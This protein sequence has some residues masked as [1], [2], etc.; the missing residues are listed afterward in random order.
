MKQ[1]RN[2]M[3]ILW[4]MLALSLSLALAACDS[5][6]QSPQNSTSLE[7]SEL[8]LNLRSVPSGVQSVMVTVNVTDLDTSNFDDS[9]NILSNHKVVSA[10]ELEKSNEVTL[11]VRAGTIDVEVYA[12][13]YVVA[14]LSLSNPDPPVNSGLLYYGKTQVVVAVS[15]IK[16]A[17]VNLLAAQSVN[18]Q[19]LTL[20]QQEDFYA[21]QFA[22]DIELPTNTPATIR[23]NNTNPDHLTL[24]ENNEEQAVSLTGTSHE[25]SLINNQPDSPITPHFLSITFAD[26]VN[27]VYYVGSTQTICPEDVCGTTPRMAYDFDASYMDNSTLENGL[28]VNFRTTTA[29]NS[30]LYFSARQ[31]DAG[32]LQRLLTEGVDLST[33]GIYQSNATQTYPV[34]EVPDPSC[35]DESCFELKPAN[36]D[37]TTAPSGFFDALDTLHL[38]ALITDNTTGEYYP[39]GTRCF[40]DLEVVGQLCGT[41][42]R[43]LNY[44]FSDGQLVLNVI[45][46][47]DTQLQFYPVANGL[48]G[49]PAASV[50][51][52]I[53]SST[54]TY[55]TTE[56]VDYT[57][58]LSDL[59]VDY[60]ALLASDTQQGSFVYLPISQFSAG[61]DAD[62]QPFLAA[63]ASE[64]V[65]LEAG[66]SQ[67]YQV[68]VDSSATLQFELSQTASNEPLELIILEQDGQT[69]AA[70]QSTNM[71]LGNN[72]GT[73][74]LSVT[75]AS[76]G[77][78][79][80]K[81]VN[82]SSQALAVNLAV[83]GNVT[84]PNDT[85]TSTTDT[86]TDT[87]T[88]TDTGTVT[89]ALP[90]HLVLVPITNIVASQTQR[91]LRAEATDWDNEEP[92]VFIS[93]PILNNPLPELATLLLERLQQTLWQ[94]QIDQG[95]FKAFVMSTDE[96]GTRA[97]NI[98]TLEVSSQQDGIGLDQVL[99]K[100]W[101]PTVESYKEVKAEFTVY[102]TDDGSESKNWRLT[103]FSD[104]P[105]FGLLVGQIDSVLDGTTQTI[106]I[107]ENEQFYA[108]VVVGDNTG[109]GRFQHLEYGDEVA[110]IFNDEHVL[111][112]YNGSQQ[113]RSR[114]D[115][116]DM[117]LDYNLYDSQGNNVNFVKDFG[118]VFHQGD[119]QQNTFYYFQSTFNP[120]PEIMAVSQEERQAIIQNGLGDFA[121]GQYSVTW[122]K[123]GLVHLEETQANAEEL[124]SPIPYNLEIP[125]EM[126]LVF[127]EGSWVLCKEFD[128]ND[129][130]MNKDRVVDLNQ[131]MKKQRAHADMELNGEIVWLDDKKM[132]LASGEEFMPEKGDFVELP[133]FRIQF[134]ENNWF[135]CIQEPG[136]MNPPET[137]ACTLQKMPFPV[138]DLVEYVPTATKATLNGL[139]ELAIGIRLIDF[140]GTEMRFR[141]GDILNLHAFDYDAEVLEFFGE[142]DLLFDDF[143]FDDEF[144]EGE[145]P[146]VGEMPVAMNML[147]TDFIE[148]TLMLQNK[149]WR[150][151]VAVDD[152]YPCS[153]LGD[154][155]DLRNLLMNYASQYEDVVGY[156]DGVE[157]TPYKRVELPNGSPYMPTHQD[158]LVFAPMKVTFEEDW[159]FEHYQEAADVTVDMLVDLDS[160]LLLVDLPSLNSSQGPITLSSDAFINWDFETVEPEQ[161]DILEVS[162][163]K[164]Q[165]VFFDGSQFYKMDLGQETGRGEV[166]TFENDFSTMIFSKE[167]YWLQVSDTASGTPAF[168]FTRMNSKGINTK[169]ASEALADITFELM[170]EGKDD[171]SEMFYHWG[172]EDIANNGPYTWD[173]EKFLLKDK[174]GN[175]ATQRLELMGSDGESYRWNPDNEVWVIKDSQ[176]NWVSLQDPIRFEPFTF[177]HEGKTI[178]LK[179]LRYDGFILEASNWDPHSQILDMMEDTR[180]MDFGEKELV[181]FDGE[182]HEHEE[183]GLDTDRMFE[184]L[185]GQLVNIPIGTEVVDKDNPQDTYRIRPSLISRYLNEVEGECQVNL[186]TP[187]AMD[188]F[189]EFIGLFPIVGSSFDQPDVVQVKAIRGKKL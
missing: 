157:L 105:Q 49:T 140:E 41:I 21:V 150:E 20:I 66:S 153:E 138:E 29:S 123:G 27:D 84:D 97:K 132:V 186:D 26:I 60:Y 80:V 159:M 51:L 38:Y 134:I 57:S 40:V 72:F 88:E 107:Q 45:N 67:L 136:Q 170:T 37:Q 32:V 82:P 68:Q 156:I 46:G 85:D 188:D 113:C 147:G 93:E 145:E 39:E 118:R 155:I 173:A 174:D 3:G 12:Y 137:T 28:R 162:F 172:G 11:A 130:C 10:A 73:L 14:G 142:D 86:S 141:N 182:E 99:I 94:D 34:T 126:E 54:S 50:S 143:D 96:D 75:P 52:S 98:W 106:Y 124:A 121:G 19:N 133:A 178:E 35:G 139:E 112:D 25:V 151:C 69:V 7:D 110:Y 6:K 129:E 108:K 79:Y 152:F 184:Y 167:A 63:E 81:V 161:G 176:G 117:Y 122:R 114:T 44:G 171:E 90:S 181:S 91:T 48:D 47:T 103:Y 183:K 24:S 164:N 128:A 15:E 187:L 42:P 165:D 146:I 74:T 127:D 144:E 115:T 168:S 125:L 5:A 2:Y 33:V 102:P 135:L 55:Q 185:R 59:T 61:S 9:F 163:V 177:E 65:N 4:I 154:T 120:F 169:Q 8:R 131:E 16:T 149:Q 71:L 111:L 62:S 180:D 53:Q 95:P 166:I 70:Y 23:Y 83:S 64:A 43:I 179:N 30:R 160:M 36:I 109:Q 31:F 189:P 175:V 77:V 78:Y 56:A 58:V 148:T 1:G 158:E 13:N 18:I 17:V 100:I 92:E 87:A 116:V 104:S 76:A 22:T 89:A 101:V 119:N